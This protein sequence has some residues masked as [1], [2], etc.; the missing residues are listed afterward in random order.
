MAVIKREKKD[1]NNKDSGKK[2]VKVNKSTN[3][4]LSLKKKKVI[5]PNKK[6]PVVVAKGNKPIS[7]D[8]PIKKKKKKAGKIIILSFQ[9]SWYLVLQ[10]WESSLLSVVTSL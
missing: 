3:S 10:L 2:I 8:K 6:S 4:L 5:K 9:S 1:A 7:P